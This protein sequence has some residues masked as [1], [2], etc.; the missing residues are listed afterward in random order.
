MFGMRKK[1]GVSIIASLAAAGLIWLALPERVDEEPSLKQP[2]SLEFSV[3]TGSVFG[4][5]YFENIY[6]ISQFDIE[7]D[8]TRSAEQQAIDKAMC[9]K[10]YLFQDYFE[11]Q[12]CPADNTRVHID[13]IASSPSKASL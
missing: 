4:G 3:D 12:P 10:D 7:R 13:Y 9:G 5:A 1:T 8:K 6:G 2:L 11:I